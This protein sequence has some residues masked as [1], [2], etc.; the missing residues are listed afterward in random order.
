M[1]GEQSYPILIYDDL[2]YTC[3]KFARIANVF[4]GGKALMVGHYSRQGRDI[5]TRLFP[6]GY[7]GLDMFWF[8]IDGRA[9]GGRAGLVRLVK[10]ALSA[11]K[12][13][14][15]RK[16]DFSLASCDTECATAKGVFMRSCS[17]LTHHNTF[18]VAG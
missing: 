10:Y 14:E 3:T 8:I 7:D 5:K 13:I 16:N 6:T 2:C 4:I 18:R 11:K 1:G 12:N 17:I 15:G 9:H